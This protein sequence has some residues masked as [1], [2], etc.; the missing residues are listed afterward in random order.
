MLFRCGFKRAN[1]NLVGKYLPKVHKKDAK[2]SALG[3]VLTSDFKRYLLMGNS[4]T[5]PFRGL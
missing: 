3:I 1:S 4:I 2:A 5:H